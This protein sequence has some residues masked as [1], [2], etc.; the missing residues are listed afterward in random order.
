MKHNEIT[1]LAPIES[2]RLENFF[3]VFQ[4]AS[5]EYFYN[6]INTINFNSD[7]IA[8]YTYN[9]YTVTLGDSYTYISYKH[10]NTINL[11][12][13]ICSFNNINNPTSLPVPGTY[14]KILKPFY[15]NTLLNKIN[16]T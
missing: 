4:E 7:N 5:G 15:V 11:W 12:W 6:I 2:T 9:W 1:D 16:K 10:Y 3:T 8:E 14:I 13:L